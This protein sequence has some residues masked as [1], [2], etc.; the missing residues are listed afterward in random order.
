MYRLSRTSF[1]L[2]G[3]VL[4]S[5]SQVVQR[6]PFRTCRAYTSIMQNAVTRIDFDTNQPEK[7]I[8]QIIE[9]KSTDGSVLSGVLKQIIPVSVPLSWK[10]INYML[11][12]KVRHFLH[13]SNKLDHYDYLFRFSKR[14]YIKI[15]RSLVHRSILRK[16]T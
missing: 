14:V 15:R 12:Q 4:H 6:I 16:T 13:N 10:L 8:E 1:K 7:I 5:R 9:Q 11:S 2:L 3:S